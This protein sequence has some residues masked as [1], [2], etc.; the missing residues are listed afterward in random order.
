MAKIK[1][2]GSRKEKAARSNLQAVPCLLLVVGILVLISLLFYALLS[3][4]K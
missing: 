2:A 3:S 4:G 1:A